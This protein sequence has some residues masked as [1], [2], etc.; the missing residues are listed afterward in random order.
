MKLRN[1]DAKWILF[2]YL[3]KNW[4]KKKTAGWKNGNCLV[5]LICWEPKKPV[6][7]ENK[8]CLYKVKQIGPSKF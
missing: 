6:S 2:S 5:N 3:D 8:T 7:E 1:R 4:N